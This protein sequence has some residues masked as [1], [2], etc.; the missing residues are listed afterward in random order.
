MTPTDLR[1]TIWALTGI[2]RF[3]G[4]TYPSWTVAD[5]IIA[6]YIGSPY[7]WAIGHNKA[8][9]AHDLPE[10]VM[11]IGDVL[12]DNHTPAIA[13]YKAEKEA[14][15]FLGFSLLVRDAS[16]MDCLTE[17]KEHDKDVAAAEIAGGVALLKP[18]GHQVRPSIHKAISDWKGKSR[19]ESFARLTNLVIIA[20]PYLQRHSD[21]LLKP[22]SR[23]LE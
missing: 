23:G 10:G 22:P 17:I 2:Q 3:N 14:E 13:A 5:H 19:R 15:F 8:W 11:G 20:F 9:L 16:F 12:R 4:M 21:V 1:N 7:K 6:G 18:D